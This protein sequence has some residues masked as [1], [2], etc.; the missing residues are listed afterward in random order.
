MNTF[1]T[2]FTKMVIIISF[3]FSEVIRN[4]LEGWIRKIVYYSM[5]YINRVTYTY[6]HQQH[7]IKVATIL[8]A[9]NQ[10]NIFKVIS[11]NTGFEILNQ[12]QAVCSD[13]VVNKHKTKNAVLYEAPTQLLRD[14]YEH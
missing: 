4:K 13:A 10:I 1:I 14:E 5:L 6:Y 3:R 2:S 8:R 12:L 9:K 11:S 7:N